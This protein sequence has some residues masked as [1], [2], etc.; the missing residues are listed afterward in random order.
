MFELGPPLAPFRELR[1]SFLDGFRPLGRP[2]GGNCLQLGSNGFKHMPAK[3]KGITRAFDQLAARVQGFV[4]Q[5]I[6]K[7]LYF[8]ETLRRPL[9]GPSR[10][11]APAALGRPFAPR[12]AAPLVR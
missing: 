10:R 2:T 9:E 3:R 4:K 12:R 1:A 7:H 8:E 11:A 6:L 5:R